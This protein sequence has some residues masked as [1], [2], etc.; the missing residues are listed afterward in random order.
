MLVFF[1][2]LTR[3]TELLVLDININNLN[4]FFLFPFKFTKL[5]F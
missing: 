5:T 4:I 1:L 2:E 3:Y